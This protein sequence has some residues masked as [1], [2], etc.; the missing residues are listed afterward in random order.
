MTPAPPANPEADRRLSLTDSL[1]IDVARRFSL[2]SPVDEASVLP[3]SLASNVEVN[4]EGDTLEDAFDDA[5]PI[6]TTPKLAH[7]KMAVL[8]LF[9][10]A[11]WTGFA[12]G[13]L[14]FFEFLKEIAAKRF[15]L[16]SSTMLDCM[17]MRTAME[18]LIKLTKSS[19]LLGRDGR[20]GFIKE[21][22]N[23][24]CS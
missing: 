24:V 22:L 1:A 15:P 3:T 11:V 5:P 12:M 21:W 16:L 8:N 20:Q 13:W 19:A 6:D 18:V 2:Q 9:H 23:T 7:C 17:T 10:A 14:Y 4:E